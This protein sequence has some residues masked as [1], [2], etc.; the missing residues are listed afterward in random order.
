MYGA[1][2]TSVGA[3]VGAVVAA[4]LVAAAVVGWGAVVGV[5][6]AVVPQAPSIIEATTNA[7]TSKNNFFMI[8]FSS[9]S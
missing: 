2:V 7:D 6:V 3:V 5:E 4:T 9:F 1:L 8:V